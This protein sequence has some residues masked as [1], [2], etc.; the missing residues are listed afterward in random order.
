MFS[1]DYII[2]QHHAASL[3]VLILCFIWLLLKKREILQGMRAESYNPVF[4]VLGL[5]LLAF[6]LL[7]P[8]VWVFPVFQLLLAW[9]AIFIIFFGK[10]MLIQSILLGIYGFSISFPLI[11]EKFAELPYSKT[12]ISPATWILTLSGYPLESHGQL[13]SFLSSTGEPIS[14]LVTSA[15]AG[16]ATM[17]VF[18]AIFAL[19]MLDTPLPRGKAG[20]VFIF[21]IVGTWVQS[22][23]RLII[24]LL[25]GY[26]RGEAA[27]WTAHSW[28]IYILFPLWYIIFLYVYFYVYN[29]INC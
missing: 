10:G 14:V 16:P 26:Y 17:G 21:G 2:G 29:K 23:I 12:I 15:C 27:L 20:Y 13:I 4:I 18:I 11:V 5:V 19:M 9:L 7:M 24:L 6:S 28:T 3:G 8:A 25:V 1:L 22:F